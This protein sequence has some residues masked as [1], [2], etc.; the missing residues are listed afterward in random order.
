MRVDIKKDYFDSEA[1]GITCL[2]V[3][4]DPA[5]K[6]LS[7]PT[8]LEEMVKNKYWDF[9]FLSTDHSPEFLEG[10]QREE[11]RFISTKNTYQKTIS[12]SESQITHTFKIL[13]KEEIRAKYTMGNISILASDL[14]VNSRYWKDIRIGRINAINLYEKWFENSIFRDYAD[15]V[16]GIDLDGRLIGLITLKNKKDSGIIDLIVVSK[17][18]RNCGVGSVL[19][20]EA[21]KYFLNQGLTKIVVETESENINANNFYIKL[22]FFMESHRLI[23][24]KQRP[25]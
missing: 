7:L 2:K 11:F 17:D 18:K 19:V 9:I 12:H 6:G 24:H 8:L 3:D 20:K 25:S 5:L 4:V 23:F 22:G 15:E 1:L 13:L 10:I 21:Q 16:I 14:V